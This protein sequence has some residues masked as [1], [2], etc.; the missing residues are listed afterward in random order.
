MSKDVED[1]ESYTTMWA[2]GI[3]HTISMPFHTSAL[4]FL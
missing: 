1:V 2:M 3:R 4:F